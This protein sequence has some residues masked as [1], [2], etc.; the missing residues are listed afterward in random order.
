M[1]KIEREQIQPDNASATIIL[2]LHTIIYYINI[3]LLHGL[4]IINFMEKQPDLL[5]CVI[6]MI[7]IISY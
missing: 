6:I 3:K 7:I 1:T 2:M 4:Y 5:L